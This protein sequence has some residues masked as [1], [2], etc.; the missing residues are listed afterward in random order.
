[1]IKNI[2]LLVIFSLQT[3]FAQDVKTYIDQL[4]SNDTSEQISVFVYD[5]VS[6]DTIYNR[7]I[8]E[9]L[10]PA[11]N[12][13]LYTTAASL[14]LLANQTYLVT[15][16]FTD[17]IN[18]EDST[19]D[20]NLYIKGYG[21]ALLEEKDLDSLITSLKEL[22]IKKI[23]GQ[24]IADESY[25]DKIYTRDDWITN[26]RANVPLPP[27]SGLSL[28]RNRVIVKF[29]TSKSLGEKPDY[30]ILPFGNFYNIEM[31]AKITNFNSRP[32][33]N[34]RTEEGNINI[35]IDGGIR[36][37]KYPYSYYVHTDS[38][39]VFI[40]SLFRDKLTR[41]GIEITGNAVSR[42][43]PMSTFE[44]A[45]V[46]HKF[47]ELVNR[48]NKESDN[49]LAETLFKILGAEYSQKQG[50][51]FYATQAVITFLE[52]H[53]IFN[54]DITIVDGSGISRYNKTSTASIVNLL[55]YIYL[56]IEHFDFFYNSLSIA[57]RDGT[58]E[59]RMYESAAYENF[60]GKTGTL[61]GVS[62]ISGYLT[63]KSNKDLIVSMLMNFSSKGQNYY[64]SIQDK[65]ISYLAEN[66]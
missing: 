21:D 19:I 25:F 34:F 50:N 52:G 9:N 40:A 10:I 42:T 1:M 44:L 38:P 12:I 46:R 39:A 59:D 60:R 41:N 32:R 64:R 29:I 45:A 11:S 54:K 14:N 65:I 22:G 17:D 24:I 63:T 15:K 36:K 51:S 30:E 56:D 16:V 43:M 66:L 8:Y 53:D 47:L 55:E 4:L 49:Y 13:K 57:G 37:R 3:V 28:D 62:S 20:G 33:I 31:N 18:F 61:N 27:I 7:N 58:L 35:R 23:D 6:M 26:E 5:P 2:V 48:V